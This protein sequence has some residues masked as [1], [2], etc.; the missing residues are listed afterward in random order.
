LL[1]NVPFGMSDRDAIGFEVKGRQREATGK[2][3]WVKFFTDSGG[4]IGDGKR[5]VAV[6]LRKHGAVTALGI[7]QPWCLPE[8]FLLGLQGRNS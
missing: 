7:A 6:R 2:R 8:V 4:C 3:P 1:C 5:P